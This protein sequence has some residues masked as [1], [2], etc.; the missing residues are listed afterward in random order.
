MK[1]NR[2]VSSCVGVGTEDV[3]LKKEGRVSL[4]GDHS[5]SW[6]LDMPKQRAI[7]FGNVQQRLYL[8]VP[9]K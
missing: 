1:N 8:A 3:K 2:G 5:Q 9:D 6:G 4:V 7:H